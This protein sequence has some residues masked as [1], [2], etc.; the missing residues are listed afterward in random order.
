MSF[1]QR[2]LPIVGSLGFLGA[3]WGAG[4]GLPEFFDRL[5]NE[6]GGL[7]A[8]R[9]PRPE[10]I[11]PLDQSEAEK[12]VVDLINQARAVRRTCGGEGT[13]APAPPLSV[14]SRLVLAARGHSSD[15]ASQDYFS[16]QGRDGSRPW[17]RVSRQG[18]SFQAVGENI[19]AGYTSPQAVV[20]GWLA[21]PGHCANLMNPKFTETG[22]G[23][24]TGGSYRIYWTQVFA[25]PR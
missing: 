9:T 7:V 12:Q 1:S 24:A 13:F 16:H 22:V 2:I 6:P 15:M 11:P 14:D 8:P 17:D 19:A 25:R 4:C 10:E 20:E 5:I 3:L 21:S 23:Q 18:Y